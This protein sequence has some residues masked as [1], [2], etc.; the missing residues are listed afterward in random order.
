[1]HNLN[2][3][4]ANIGAKAFF[5]ML[6]KH[7]F[8]HTDCHAGNILVKIKENPDQITTKINDFLQTTK[9]FLI[10]Q[11]IKYGFDSEYLRKLSQDHYEYE[12]EV[13]SL[14]HKFK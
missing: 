6:F 13:H 10:A 12:K 9:N 2:K 3:V 11:V 5:A 14:G 8:V 7:N 1:V 4:I